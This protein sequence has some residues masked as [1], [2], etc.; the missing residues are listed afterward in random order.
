MRPLGSHTQL[1]SNEGSA[2]EPGAPGILHAMSAESADPPVSPADESADRD[3]APSQLTLPGAAPEATS[4]P[5][6]Q[7]TPYPLELSIVMPC[8]DEAETLRGCIQNA[9]AFLEEQQVE[10]EVVIADNG[11]RDGSPEIARRAG[12]RVVHV[13]E[14]GYGNALQGGIEAARG[15]FVIMG[16]AD[17][18]YD[19]TSLDAFLERLRAGD[20]LVMGNRFAGGVEPGAMP[21]LHRYLGNPILSALGRIFFAAPVSDFHCG[22]RGFSN[23]AY[24]RMALRAGGMEFASEMVVK[25]TLLGMRISEVP[26]TLRRDGRSRAPHL[27]TWRDGWR[28]LRFMLLFSPRWLFLVPGLLLLALGSGVSLLLLGGGAEIAGITFD[29]HTLL[30]AG[31]A[32]LLGYQL[33]VFAVFSKVFAIT[34]GFQPMPPV[35]GRVFERV[36]LETGLVVGLLLALAGMATIGAALWE[37]RSV[38]FGGLDPRVTMRQVIPG[39]ELVVLGFQ[40]VFSSFFLSLLGLKRRGQAL[41]E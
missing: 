36:T 24:Q 10:G 1:C 7:A 28:H 33:V 41:H 8:L 11:S 22:L 16:D 32:C 18:S 4:E 35:L 9:Q 21:W 15:R 37:W 34:E 3:D 39:T 40:T 13:R 38:D 29:I 30:V 19:F 27:R 23:D 25:A 17:D 20:E 5:R 6:S 31:L 12:A 2:S 26:T 14:P